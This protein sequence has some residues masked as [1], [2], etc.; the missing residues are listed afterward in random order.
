MK[1]QIKAP[2]TAAG[3]LIMSV[4]LSFFCF[5]IFLLSCWTDRNIE[6]WATHFKGESVDCPFWLSVAVTIVANGVCILCNVIAE[7]ARLF[8]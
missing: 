1:T 2:G 6:F 3:C 8:I 4:F 7:V 5:I